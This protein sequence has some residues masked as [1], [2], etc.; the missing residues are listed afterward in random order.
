MILLAQLPYN[1]LARERAF[2][3]TIAKH[4]PTSNTLAHLLRDVRGRLGLTHV[5]MGERLGISASRYGQ[6]ETG[7][8]LPRDV[9]SIMTWQDVLG[10][11]AVE[12]EELL[13]VAR[14]ERQAELL[15]ALVAANDITTAKLA[16]HVA[17][18]RDYGMLI[19]EGLQREGMTWM[20]LIQQ[21]NMPNRYIKL[22]V[23]SYRDQLEAVS[24]ILHLD[25]SM[26]QETVTINYLLR[27]YQVLLHRYGELPLPA[28]WV[29]LLEQGLA[30]RTLGISYFKK[31]MEDN[32]SYVLRTAMRKQ[33]YSIREFSRRLF[34]NETK[35]SSWL[36]G[37]HHPNYEELQKMVVVL[38]PQ[39]DKKT[40]QHIISNWQR[41]VNK[42]KARNALNYA[43]RQLNLSW[44]DVTDY[45]TSP[46]TTISAALDHA[47]L[48]AS[49][50]ER[51]HNLK[52][53]T[54][55]SYLRGK[56]NL[57]SDNLNFIHRE[58]NL[59]RN[60]TEMQRAVKVEKFAAKYH[61]NVKKFGEFI[62]NPEQHDAL[63]N[64]LRIRDEAVDISK[65]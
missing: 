5:E 9:A 22:P 57:G 21:S 14:A 7:R 52:K 46:I 59:T 12:L 2:I 30:Q 43:M 20:E 62:S 65:R 17:E 50:F 11:S 49:Q 64:V 28:S 27:R 56:R 8:T 45:N 39:A 44:D 41:L 4:L 37:S 18:N 3:T 25:Y 29:S 33:D 10:K 47:G 26:L 63:T 23:P 35:V 13:H 34:A 58:L 54:L 24:H 16:R 36:I 32:F 1:A 15:M 31:E 61:H 6:T 55:Y 51:Q 40:Q 38:Y 60:L 19:H 53:T 48:S 42:I